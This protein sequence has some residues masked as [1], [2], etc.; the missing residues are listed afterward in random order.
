MDGG[1][2]TY[3]WH[4]LTGD[5]VFSFKLSSNSLAWE[6]LVYEFEPSKSYKNQRHTTYLRSTNKMCDHDHMFELIRQFSRQRAP[7]GA[8]C[9]KNSGATKGIVGFHAYSLIGAVRKGRHKLLKLRN[10][11]GSGEWKGAWSD[12]DANWVT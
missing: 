1:Q 12:G 4:L 8:S 5:N 11:W 10:P 2:T 7:M 9:H 6:T 3:A